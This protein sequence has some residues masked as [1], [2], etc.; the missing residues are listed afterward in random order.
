MTL[1][2]ELF[3]LEI[4]KILYLKLSKLIFVFSLR[5][6]VQYLTLDTGQHRPDVK[7]EL[8][9]ALLH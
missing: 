1:F 2:S 4:T 5:G 8:K 6:H 3:C 9:C 7:C